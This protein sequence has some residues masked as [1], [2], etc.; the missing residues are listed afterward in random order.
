MD[1]PGKQN[2]LSTGKRDKRIKKR[3][4]FGGQTLYFGREQGG[5]GAGGTGGKG[6]TGWK[7]ELRGGRGSPRCEM[8]GRE[9]NWYAG[10]GAELSGRPKADR[11]RKLNAGG[12]GA[13]A[14]L[15]AGRGPAI[16][17][18]HISGSHGKSYRNPDKPRAPTSRI[19]NVCGTHRSQPR[20]S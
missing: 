2:E 12:R 20:P 17:T 16:I 6:P 14:A 7:Q 3:D 4:L 15:G 19:T 8:K 13:G 10:F 9:G 11:P 1:S 18:L 5:L